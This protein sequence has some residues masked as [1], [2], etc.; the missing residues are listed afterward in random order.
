MAVGLAPAVANSILDTYRNAARAG[1]N[2]FCR[3]HTGDPGA[4]GAANGSAVTTRNAVTFAAPSGGSMSL[5]ALA[6]YSMTTTETI[7][8]ISLWDA[9]AAGNFLHS[10]ALTA[11]V[12]VINGSTLTFSA[13]TVS[14]TPLAA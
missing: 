9:A 7:T 12:P 8:H 13:L 4:A 14:Y 11:A 10:A 3:L 6:A 1:V 2:V 5:S